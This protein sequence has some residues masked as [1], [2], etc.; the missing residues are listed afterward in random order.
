MADEIDILLKFY[1]EDWQQARQAENQRTA[2][3]NITLII[4][5]ALIGFVAQ[6]GFGDNAL[7]L[8]ILLFIL[9]IYGAITSQKLYERHCYFSDRSGLWRDRISELNLKLGIAQIRYDARLK[10]SR[11]FKRLEKV[12]LY[13]LWLVLHLFVSLAGLVLTLLILFL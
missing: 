4:V 1:E 13:S 7:P 8:T 12:R 6:Q 5:P 2:I 10:H 11:R 3:T 9:G